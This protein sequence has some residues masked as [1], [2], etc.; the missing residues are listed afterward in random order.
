[1][2]RLKKAAG[3][4]E[5]TCYLD[6]NSRRTKG[7]ITHNTSSSNF[8]Y[9]SVVATCKWVSAAQWYHSDAVSQRGS[10]CA[11]PT[12]RFLKN[13]QLQCQLHC[14]NRHFEGGN[15]QI[16]ITWLHRVSHINIVG[17]KYQIQILDNFLVI[18]A[19]FGTSKRKT[20]TSTGWFREVFDDPISI[21][22][23]IPKVLVPG[24][25]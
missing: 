24:S 11:S 8:Y 10:V 21:I 17:P 15:A 13:K 22:S 12:M 7:Q 16:V 25:I 6:G 14:P 23:R 20:M 2:I 9:R 5:S 18:Y 3:K 19:Q 4:H 1:M